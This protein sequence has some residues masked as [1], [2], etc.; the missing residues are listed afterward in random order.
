MLLKSGNL[1]EVARTKVEREL[2]LDYAAPTSTIASLA[3][4]V[5]TTLI[6]ATITAAITAAITAD[7]TSIANSDFSRQRILTRDASSNNLQARIQYSRDRIHIRFD[8]NTTLN[9]RSPL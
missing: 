6:T 1:S 9:T 2:E 5:T 8:L 3:S 4:S 7:I